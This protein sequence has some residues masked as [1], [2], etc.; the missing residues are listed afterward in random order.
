MKFGLFYE[1]QMPRPWDNDS[2]H[3]L[4][5]DS[6]DQA[7]LADKLGY[8]CVWEVEHHFLDEY[9]HSPAPEVFLAACSQRTSQ[10]RLGHGIV[11]HPPAYN[12]PARIAERI[13]AL[14][15]VSNGRV[16]WG[17]GESASRME[18]EAFGVDPS[19]KRGMWEESV[20]ETAKMMVQTPYAG[21]SGD[22]FSMP[23]RNVI[24]K[25]LQKPHPPLWVA[26]SSRETI[27]RAARLG[28]GALTFAFVNPEEARGW[29]EEYY[30]VFE[31]ECDPIGRAV[32]PNIAM[33]AGFSCHPDE[34][35]AVQRGAE[36]FRYFQFALAHYYINGSHTPGH[37]DIWKRFQEQDNKP[38]SGGLGIG[39]PQQV[40]ERLQQMEEA[41]VDQVVFL[42]Q[43]G[44]NRHEHICESLQV[45]AEEVMPAF[46]EREPKLL[47]QKQERLA[48]AVAAAENRMPPLDPFP[49]P[50]EPVD[51]YPLMRE[52]QDEA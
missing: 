40:G 19:Q 7:E 27:R 28:I 39:A 46:K 18:L 50:G 51:A 42:Q 31:E 8:D 29:V 2:E 32:N 15:L 14:D 22:H 48:S 3:R 16:E 12:H 23:C 38:D 36:G 17:T 44:K 47:A 33:V 1:H 43:A 34:K 26:C 24:P 4:Y 5:Q 52:K 9:S 10:I 35:T 6:L 45:F 30:R 20:R 37:T 11:L 25:P 13:A 21:Y 49:D 41:G